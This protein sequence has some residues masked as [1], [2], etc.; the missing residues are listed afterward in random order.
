MKGYSQCPVWSSHSCLYFKNTEK[1]QDNLIRCSQSLSTNH[2]TILANTSKIPINTY[3]QYITHYQIYYTK[4]YYVLLQKNLTV[5]STWGNIKTTDLP[6][7]ADQ[8]NF[9]VNCYKV[10]KK[11]TS[12]SVSEG[13]GMPKNKR[14]TAKSNSK[15]HKN[16]QIYF[17]PL[18]SNKSNQPKTG[19]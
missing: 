6:S 16:L 5:L 8:L 3:V 9:M 10:E 15:K 17:F 12:F 2:N 13:E 1:H 4:F 18:S 11:K 19:K 14:C 7:F